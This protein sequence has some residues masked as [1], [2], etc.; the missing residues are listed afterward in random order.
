MIF[1]SFL[2]P[3]AL[4]C[5]FLAF[6]MATHRLWKPSRSK[7]KYVIIVYGSILLLSLPITYIIASFTD[8]EPGERMIEHAQAATSE[9]VL[10]IEEGRLPSAEYIRA[11][12]EWNL[13][14]EENKP[15]SISIRGQRSKSIWIMVERNE[16]LPDDQIKITY[17][18]TPNVVDNYDFSHL[19]HPPEVFIIGQNLVIHDDN[20]PLELE[21]I[22][23]RRETFIDQFLAEDSHRTQETFIG[24]ELLYMEVPAHLELEVMNNIELILID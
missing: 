14:Y 17:Y 5:I 9:F 20:T 2:L 23:F 19:I 11:I 18:T 3:I 24:K 21:L 4:V 7:T 13:R 16:Q 22:G 6:V 10:A 8:A 15:L 1:I 12:E